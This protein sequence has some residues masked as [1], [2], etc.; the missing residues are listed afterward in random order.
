[1][2]KGKKIHRTHLIKVY[3]NAAHVRRAYGNHA[4]KAVPPAPKHCDT[5]VQYK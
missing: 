4:E 3:F 2:R 1:M 5:F